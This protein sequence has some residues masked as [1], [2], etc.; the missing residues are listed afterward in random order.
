MIT[1]AEEYQKYLWQLQ[2]QNKPVSAILL[3]SDENIY[4]INLNTRTINAPEFLSVRKDH[5][6]ETVYFLVDRF[7]DNMDL[8]QTACV[9]Q[10]KNAAGEEHIFPVPFYDVTTFTTSIKDDFLLTIVK[11]KDYTINTYYIK[12]TQGNFV[13]SK[14]AFNENENYYLKTKPYYNT[15]YVKVNL[16]AKTYSKNSFYYMDYDKE[17]KTFGQYTQ[18]TGDF[19]QNTN[20]FA[21]IDKRFVQIALTSS[22]YRRNTYYIINSQGNMEIAS[23]GFD[24][25]TAYFEFIDSPKLMF[26]WI[27]SGD[28]T[29]QEGTI[30]FAVRFYISEGKQIEGTSPAEFE[31]YTIYDLN[32]KPTTSKVLY[33]MDNLADKETE[34]FEAT[35]LEAIYSRLNE[36]EGN[37]NLYWID[38]DA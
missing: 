5:A 22:T 15:K 20:Y 34:K 26:P 13:L 9:I 11:E 24:T 7:Y 36:L 30:E 17:S 25:E 12:D 19:E 38:A 37:Y 18:A 33:G 31:Y 10:Y 35:A 28:V 21:K 29:A 2:D 14:G 16:T 1:T 27:I 3:P 32:T 8:S 6:A 23:G 4:E